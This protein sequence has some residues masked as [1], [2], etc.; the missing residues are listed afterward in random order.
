MTQPTNLH[1]YIALVST[2]LQ[3]HKQDPLSIIT[4][5]PYARPFEIYQPL[6][7]ALI[8]ALK[9][10]DTDTVSIFPGLYENVSN[11]AKYAHVIAALR[12]NNIKIV[13]EDS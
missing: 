11:N 12:E 2:Q 1:K 13:K 3:E 5:N 4:G 7:T 9:T 10:L 8:V 6:V